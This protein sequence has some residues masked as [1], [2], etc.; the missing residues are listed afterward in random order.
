MIHRNRL[1]TGV[2]TAAGMLIGFVVASSTNAAIISGTAAGPEGSHDTWNAP[3]NWDTAAVPTGAVDAEVAAGVTAEV[4]NDLT[5][6]YTGGLTLHTG[7]T[8]Q[9]GWTTSRPNSQNALGGSGIT[10][11]DGSQLRLRMPDPNPFVLPGIDM[12]GNASIHLSPSTSAH[13]RT[14]DFDGVITGPG[15][16]TLIGNNNNTANLNTANPDWSGGFVADAD[17]SWRVNANVSG[18][19]GTGDVTINGD[20][21]PTDRGA[22]LRINAPNVMDDFATLYLNGGYDHRE[23]SKL[24]LNADDTI[25]AFFLDGVNLGVGTFDQASGLVDFLGRDLITGGGTLTVTGITSAPST[26]PEPG[27]DRALVADRA[28]RG[29]LRGS[30]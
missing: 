12:Q 10:M 5:P 26:V 18:A 23:P 4:W 25:G 29:R 11:H 7:S 21:S 20:A 27:F 28:G 6:S 15:T 30:P 24:I 9:L 3:A 13:H 16:L 14:R 19:F 8:L 17:D 1:F 22:S 2:S